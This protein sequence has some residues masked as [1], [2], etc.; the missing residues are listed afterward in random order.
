M[1]AGNIGYQS[2]IRE[3]M[4]KINE[5]QNRRERRRTLL[6]VGILITMMTII[7]IIQYKSID[8]FDKEA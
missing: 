6:G 7:G 3:S 4:N 2:A 5:F 1:R 8:Y